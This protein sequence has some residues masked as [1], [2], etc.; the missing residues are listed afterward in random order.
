V[1][2][3]SPL[4]LSPS[5][6]VLAID[7]GGTKLA[8]AIVT[9]AGRILAQL[10]EPSSQEG[11]EAGV[12]QIIRMAKAILPK[13]G[14]RGKGIGGVAAAVGVGLPAA[15]ETGSD[16]VFWAANLY[17]WRNVALRPALESALGLPVSIENDGHT[18]TLAEYRFGAGRG[19]HNL[20]AVI[21]GTGIGGG[22]ILDDR[23]VRGANRLAGAAGWF[24]LT[25]DPSA[26]DERVRT[27]GSWE[28]LAAGPGLA[29]QAQAKLSEH[30]DSILSGRPG[31]L[32]AVQVF[33]AAEAGDPYAGQL[34]DDLAGILGLGIANIV[35]LVNP[36][37]V[38]LGG[39]V[40]SR[41]ERLLP[42][43]QE[44]IQRWAQPVSAR[45]VQLKVSPL[46]PRAGLLGAACAAWQRLQEGLSTDYTDGRR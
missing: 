18:A 13:Q 46:G 16:F 26:G 30:P 3:S 20:A 14:G 27:L 28:A 37:V 29:L 40:G 43:I 1:D 25:G 6:P 12:A 10:Q 45:T 7:L 22:L 8:L 34:L 32:S 4:T 39:G 23:L 15:L 21:V 44:V 36:Q 24:A 41:C 17:G 19:F 33:D 9:S 11:P 5:S 2:S 35:S 38:V 31:P 42:R